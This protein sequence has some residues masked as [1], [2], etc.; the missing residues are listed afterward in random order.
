[1]GQLIF[2][3][4][5]LRA[6]GK[7]RIRAPLNPFLSS[8]NGRAR[9][10]RSTDFYLNIH[11]A[12]G[13]DDIRGQLT[14]MADDTDNIVN[15]A[16]G[17]QIDILLGLGGNDTIDGG[18]GNDE[19]SGG[20][21]NDTLNGGASNDLLDP[22]G[23][24]KLFGGNGDDTLNGG[25]GNDMLDG[26]NDNDTLNGGE[27]D[28]TLLGGDGD[29]IINGGNQNDVVEGGA[30]ADTLNGGT[31]F[32]TLSYAGDT[33]GVTIDLKV[34]RRQEAKPKATMSPSRHSGTSPEAAA[35]TR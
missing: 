7:I 23:D 35:T 15:G 29:D 6:F 13:N 22:G 31:G 8:F 5:E 26:G 1:M 21:G 34:E 9:V 28:N 2:R 32:N 16:T 24:D 3:C 10:W 19:L 12:S 20:D 11:T 25:D 33:I 17:Y 4:G 14:L 18:R 30:G 27:G